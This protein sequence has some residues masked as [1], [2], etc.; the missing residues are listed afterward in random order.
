[1]A[2]MQV[3]SEDLLKLI[4]R[5]KPSPLLFVKEALG[6]VPE[7]WQAEALEAL[8]T[9]DRVSIKAGHGVGK[10]ALLAWLCI[11]FLLTHFPCKI[12]ITANSQDQLRDV[13]WPEI[14]LWIRRLPPELA[15]LL[16]VTAEK[17][18]LK[19]AEDE[20]FAVARTA[21]KERPEALQGFHADNI[22]FLIEEASGIPDIVFEVAI[23]ALSTHGAKAAMFSNP[24]R[25]SGFFFDSHHSL[26]HRWHGITVNCEDYPRAKGHIEDIIAR[27]GKQSNAYRIRVLGEF[28]TT[29][30][31]QVI[32]ME[33]IKA[34]IGRKIMTV[35]RYQPVWGLDVARFGDDRT[36]LAKRQ[37]NTLLEPIKSWRGKDTMQVA[38]LVHREW[39]DTPRQMRPSEIL[40][41]VIGIGAGVVDR[42]YELGLPVRAVNVAERAAASDKYLRQR[43][44]LWWKGR[45]WFESLKCNIPLDE[46]LIGEL[47]APTYTL[48]SGG[49][50]VIESKDD[51]KKRIARSPDLADAF[52]LTLAAGEGVPFEEK[53][54]EDY[55]ATKEE[56]ATTWMSA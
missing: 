23:G 36:A 48:S 7:K 9:E 47:S 49:K 35:A 51:M 4:V 40:V 19:S 55:W 5:W 45:E 24:T 33:L 18:C 32:P 1:M 26:S 46:S 29:E 12:P 56:R 10:T 25:L 17:V 43:D 13:V 11:W 8:A 27:F 52:L 6:A 14:A 15:D 38:G 31:Q 30:D 50:I 2:S 39:Q 21:S 34:A 53:R 28:P 3:T 22:L 44:E 41:D 54:S 42:L 16:V 20:A 37:N